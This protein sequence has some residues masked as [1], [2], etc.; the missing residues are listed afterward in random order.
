[1][2]GRFAALLRAARK[3]RGLSKYALAQKAGM[4]RQGVGSLEDGSNTPTWESVQR[5]AAALHVPCD[6]FADPDLIKQLKAIAPPAAR[7]R[8]SKR[9]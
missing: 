8:P 6:Y 9:K 1:M 4:S 3:E 7:G 2:G 5:L